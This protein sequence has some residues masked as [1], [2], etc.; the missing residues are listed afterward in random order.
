MQ[1]IGKRRLTKVAL[2]LVVA[3]YCTVP[4]AVAAPDGNLKT[5]QWQIVTASTG[6][7]QGT[8]PWITRAADKVAE[9]DK[10]HVT[11]TIDRGTRAITND[12][13]RQFH[14]GDTVTIN[15]AIGDTEGDLDAQNTATKATVQWMSY[16]DQSGGNPKEIGTKGSSSYE[17]QAADADRY[18]GI[19]ITPTTTTGDPSVATVLLL[20]D[21]STDA[22]GGADDDDIPEG[23]VVNEN[24]KVVI[25]E[26]GSTSNLLGTSTKLKTN[27]TYKVLLWA[28]KNGDSK[29][30]PGEEVT[31]EY[32]YRWKFT[33]T[34]A[35]AATGIPGIVN[36]K[37]NNQD[38]VIPVTNAEAKT[39][40]EG[41][42]NGV[43]VGPD[44][45]QG[46]GLSVD[47]RRK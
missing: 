32:D 12:G 43:T 37:Y 39:E 35:I 42:E 25:Y 40:F 33:G 11:L 2:A 38:L 36:G 20:N 21:L 5:G 26:S 30:N 46:F 17:I 1:A 16:S 28:D 7:I 31:S 8:V 22:G 41:A 18:I 14:V 44:G 24:V 6:T 45:V 27:T 15:W 10:N 4:A 19:Q 47:F 23:P 29:Y 34:S 3:G 9:T 13:D